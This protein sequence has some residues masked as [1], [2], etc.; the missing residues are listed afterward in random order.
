MKRFAAIRLMAV[1]LVLMGTAGCDQATK[2]LARAGL[3][4]SG[5]TLLPGGFVEFTLAE[6]PGAFLSLGASMPAAVRGGLLTIAVGLGLAFLLA[7]L[8]RNAKLEW[9]SF[10]GL[11]LIWAGGMS[12]LVDR[13]WRHGHV[14]DFMVI[15]A[16]A[17]HTGIFN[18]ADL[19][20]VVGAL[21]LA[22]WWCAGLC[23]NGP[24][25]A[26]NDSSP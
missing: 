12:N 26:G 22:A 23:K 17:F 7:H 20:I 25:R 4:Q 5:S 1:L 16:G 11:T 14:T 24:H 19:A 8:L 18:V 9:W 15:R 6:N 13:L 2:H 10:L 21:T 3:S